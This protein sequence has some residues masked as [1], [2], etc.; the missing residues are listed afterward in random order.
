MIPAIVYTRFSPRRN[1]DKAMSSETQLAYCKK[2]AEAH[3]LT[4][5]QVFNDRGI[6]GKEEE[7]PKLWAAIDALDE[8]SVLLVFKLDRLARNVYLSECIRRAVLKVGAKIIAIQGDVAGEGPEQ[9]MIRQVLACVAEYE[10]KIIG[11]RTK[12]AMKHHQTRGRRMGR[13]APYGLMIDPKDPKKLIP[14]PTEEPAMKLI[15]DLNQKD[16]VVSQIT[17]VMQKTMR[18]YARAAKGWDRRTVSRI[19]E[20]L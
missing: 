4:I 15:A 2:Y 9:I 10:R 5:V 17:R 7:R 8:G 19:L 12:Y 14:D 18:K 20:R 13:Y 11:I 16:F 1:S 3:G 6:S